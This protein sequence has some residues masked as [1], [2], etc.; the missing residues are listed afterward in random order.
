MAIGASS[1]LVGYI[2]KQVNISNLLFHLSGD[3]STGKTT[4]L[5]LA[6]T[7]HGDVASV[8]DKTSLLS[9]FNSTDNALFE[10]LSDNF[11][12]AIGID[13]AGM[14]KDKSFASLIYRLVEGKEKSR[15]EY[16]AGNKD[17]R[18]WRTAIITTGE[19][20]LQDYTDRATGQGVRV[21]NFES[22][23][24]TDSAVQSDRIK[25][26]LLEHNGFLSERIGGYL[27]KKGR[28][29]LVKAHDSEME[30][31]KGM[32]SCGNLNSRVQM[33]V[34]PNWELVA[35]YT[36][37]G[38]SGTK[39]E[40]RE[41][42]QRMITDASDGKINL[43]VT[44]EI[45]RFSRNLLDTLQY[46]RFL[47]SKGCE[48]FFANE[49]IWSWDSDGE[50]RISMLG[51]LAQDASRHTSDRAK[52]GQEISRNNGMLYGRGNIMGYNLLKTP[53]GESNRYVIDQEQ[54]DT[55]RMIFD[56]YLIRDMGYKA[57][58]SELIAK[59]RLNPSG[60]IKWGA[61]MVGRILS[62]RVYAGYLV[63][64]QSVCTDFLSHKR[65]NLPASE[66]IYVKAPEDIVPPIITDEQ[67]EA[68]Q[69]K[70]KAHTTVKK[71][72]A[73]RGKLAVKEKWV[74]KLKCSCG[75]SYKRFKW[76]TNEGT[77][78][79]VF[80]YQCANQVNHRKRSYIEAQGIDGEGFCNVRSIARWKLEIQLAKMLKQIWRSPETTISNL[81]GT[82]EQNY[83]EYQERSED[84]ETARLKREKER[85]EQRMK[86]LLEMRLDGEIDKARYLL[87]KES[88]ENGL[89]KS[90]RH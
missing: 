42:F 86:N 32:L 37:K 12:V 51:I 30:R 54:A 6:V 64:G 36:D 88:L 31:I 14:S 81:V 83:V 41:A 47:K 53:R 1:L 17:V 13:E 58:C 55:V 15:L 74:K 84:K 71:G 56:M 22:T 62:K 35:E 9:T 72:Q 4:A 70:R 65:K 75:S 10:L 46:A 21:I 80:G 50:L 3:S 18:E 69:V 28:K 45:S 61:N 59:Q 29:V 26:T 20:P 23:P 7:V 57:I 11:G 60:V 87:E 76:R 24:W 25:K 85:K 44:R 5:W 39:A 40:N 34:H 77:G 52:A 19:I 49:G 16:G 67:W 90:I 33:A 89:M 2:G 78:E 27:L 79:E 66:H 48:V 82:I 8:P 68:A 38:L 43:I 73:N 63:Y